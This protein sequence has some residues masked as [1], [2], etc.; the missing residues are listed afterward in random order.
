MH[1]RMQK[2]NV[3]IKT[4]A[5]K[6]LNEQEK[7]NTSDLLY[8]YWTTKKYG[9]IIVILCVRCLKEDAKALDIWKKEI[10]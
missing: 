3:F 6:F 1:W 5:L 4:N 9:Q 8:I 2:K 10:L 7:L